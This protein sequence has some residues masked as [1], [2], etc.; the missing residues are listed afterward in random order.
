MSGMRNKIIKNFIIL[1]ML[2]GYSGLT[3]AQENPET[4]ILVLEDIKLH[5]SSSIPARIKV[6]L[7]KYRNRKLD[8]A[9]VNNIYSEI[10][11]QCKS[12]GYYLVKKDSISLETFEKEQKTVLHIYLSAGPQFILSMVETEL[13]DSLEAAYGP[14]V[15]SGL[16][17]F[18]NQPYTSERQQKMFGNILQIFENSGYPLCRITTHGFELDSLEQD[19][20]GFRLRLMI[21]P[22]DKI[23]L[24]GLKLPAKAV[25]DLGYIERVLNFT[26]AEVY[27]EKRISRY[28]RILQRQDFIKTTQKPEIISLPDSNYYL[29]LIFEKAPSTIFDG[30]V[31]YIPPPVN[32]PSQN[33]YFSG[34]FNIG[35]RNL[36][37]TGRRLDVYWQKPDKYSEDFRVK[38]REPFLVGLP[39]HLGGMFHRLIRDT[40]Y[41]EWEYSLNAEIPLNETLTGLARIYSRQVFPDSLASVVQRLPQTKSFHTEL[42]IQWDTRDDFYNPRS[43]LLFNLQYDY[44]TQRNV[45][46]SYL[47]EQDSLIEKSKVTKVKGQFGYFLSTFTRQVLAL[48]LQGI[49]IGQQ[50]QKVRPPDMFWFGGATTLRGYREDQFYGEKVG[51]A[52]I[53]YRFLLAPLARL[54]FFT[55]LGYYERE[56]PDVK[57]EFLSGYGLGI[58]FPGPLGILQVDFGM[59]KGLS[60]SEGKLHFRLINDF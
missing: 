27:N 41:I 22:G 30:I 34:M 38:Y 49:L 26:A 2:E 60:F 45:G 25:E 56:L 52:N 3:L 24:S 15:K 4:K 11:E 36:F 51:W 8:G 16:T 1:L 31:G 21:D 44:G 37:G 47:L 59:A 43:G 50:G 58:S 6:P 9:N 28:Q 7:A 40:T 55:D 17:D 14:L 33:G 18:L 5:F 12:A 35:L 29:K 39:F 13:P 42:G 10:A 48:Q 32:D 57:D 54:F 53:E 20:M 46:P 23:H 19:K